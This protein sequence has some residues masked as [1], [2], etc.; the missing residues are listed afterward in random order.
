MVQTNTPSPTRPPKDRARADSQICPRC[1]HALYECACTDRWE[2]EG[3]AIQP[4]DD[5]KAS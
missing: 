4:Q 1:G 3:G 5:D 2:N